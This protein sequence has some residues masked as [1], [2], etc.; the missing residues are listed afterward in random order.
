MEEGSSLMSPRQQR[1]W[2]QRSSSLTHF[3]FLLFFV[4]S[5]STV[6]GRLR[7]SQKAVRTDQN[8]RRKFSASPP[9]P[10]HKTLLTSLSF[11]ESNRRPRRPPLRPNLVNYLW[12]LL[13][14][15][16]CA[17]FPSQSQPV[18]RGVPFLDQHV[19]CQQQ[20]R[21]WCGTMGT[22]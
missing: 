4:Q 17:Q 16:V 10:S 20:Q 1:I 15:L 7:I 5:S 14:S 3:L 21:R 22:E 19:G 12:R 8:R 11:S 9:F 2:T 13:L 18:H 6:Q